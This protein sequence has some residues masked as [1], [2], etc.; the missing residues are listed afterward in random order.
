M[1]NPNI[2][3][4]KNLL[5]PNQ[6]SICNGVKF[7]FNCDKCDHIF[8]ISPANIKQKHWCSYCSNQILCGDEECS[9][10]FNKSFAI[11]LKSKFW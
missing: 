9:D 11:N 10:C 8:Y 3:A 2:G 1:K 4:K 7:L 6:V 5:K